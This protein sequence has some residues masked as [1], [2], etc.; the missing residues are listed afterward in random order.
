LDGFN[1]INPEVLYLNRHPLRKPL[2]TKFSLLGTEIEG[3]EEYDRNIILTRSITATHTI[4]LKYNQN[5]F[6]LDFSALNFINPT[7]TFYR[8]KLEGVDNIWHEIASND[9]SG[10]ATYINLSPGNYVFKTCAANNFKEWGDD[11]AELNIIVLP[12]LWKTTWAYM[13]YILFIII[14]L[15]ECCRKYIYAC[16]DKDKL[17]KIIYNL[18]SN[19]FKFTPKG[20]FIHIL[21][22]YDPSFNDEKG[23]LHIWV[24]DSGCGIQEKDL[25]HIFTRFYRAKGN[26]EN[27]QGSGIGLHIVQEYVQLHNGFVNVESKP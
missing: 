7:Q 18:L 6:S 8:Y 14:F 25:P 19:A 23:A 5:F 2:F 4:S 17:N 11:F 1:I 9:G 20:G 26:G 15:V 12:P 10:R 24:T 3:R 27:V 21:F 13:A 22:D 16:V